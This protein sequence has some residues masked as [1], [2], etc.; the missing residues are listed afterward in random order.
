MG[1]GWGFGWR[2]GSIR[3]NG[4]G[5]SK[6]V[7]AKG[8]ADVTLE[9][10]DISNV[11][12]GIWMEGKS[13]TVSGGKIGFMRDYGVYV[14]KGVRAELTGVTIEGRGGSGSGYGVY[15]MGG[16]VTVSGVNVSQVETGVY[17][18]GGVLMVIGGEI[19]GVKEGI[20]MMG[21]GVLKVKDGTRIEFTGNYGVY[22][23]KRVKNT[24]L[25]NVEI[26]GS[27][28]NGSKGVGVW[29]E[30]GSLTVSRGSIKGVKAGIAMM[31]GK[32]LTVKDGTK[33]EFVGNY[34][35][36]VYVGKKVTRASLTGVKI[37]GSGKGS[38]TGVYAM[39]EKVMMK[40]VE[41]SNVATGVEMSD[42]VM[43]LKETHL[44]DVAK[45]MTIEEAVVVMVEGSVEFKGEH[46]IYFKQGRAALKG[47]TMRYKSNGS[48]AN[49][50]KVEDGVV[51][52]EKLT[53]T[54]NGGKGQGVKVANGGAVWLKET[55]F[56]NVRSGMTV[57]RGGIMR[58]EGGSITFTG[59]HG[60]DVSGGQALLTGFSITRQ[61][62]TSKATAT[63]TGVGVSNLGEV[64]MR[65]VNISQVEM[66]ARVTSGLLVMDKG[67][68][69]FKRDYG[70]NLVSGHAFLN[71]V[72]ITGPGSGTGI[73]LG[74]GQVLM[75]GTTF[76]N[77]DKAITVTQGDVKMEGGEITFTGE[78]G[79]LLKQGGVALMGVTM[80]YLCFHVCFFCIVCECFVYFF[81]F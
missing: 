17:A 61:G 1:R 40:Q 15:A 73:E 68:I 24:S 9:R 37:T 19:K 79:I 29:V 28:N 31:G 49:F 34:G 59:G 33:I 75:K 60:I 2:G 23:G 5:G 74:Y 62:D 80:T 7:Y 41:I 45:G 77:V 54:G 12:T 81:L 66:G 64:M 36:G 14:G 44:R 63:G 57:E 25:T 4:G 51:L 76:T 22:A 47:I 78:H 13:L 10:V 26:T 50:I 8:N 21:Y 27:G 6:G 18:M 35:Y 71:G 11:E 38:G 65:D 16:E 55:N 70:I 39:G 20:K 67:S 48:N 43:W 32:S 42:G 53:M 72:K 69:I 58:M 30:G 46:G 56:T 52:A 3:G